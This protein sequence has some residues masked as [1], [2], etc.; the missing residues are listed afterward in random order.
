VRIKHEQNNV[1]L[2]DDL[3]QRADVVPP[4][5]LFHIVALDRCLLHHSGRDVADAVSHASDESV[6]SD[7]IIASSC[8]GSR[9]GDWAKRIGGQ[10]GE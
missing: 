9:G 7:A 4:Q 5:L 10:V 3:V 6:S 8:G 2:V 1:G